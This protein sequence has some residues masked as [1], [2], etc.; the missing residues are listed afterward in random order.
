MTERVLVL[1]P[2]G[3][4]AAN[5]S[6]VLREAGLKP[7]VCKDVRELCAEFS[8]GAGALL[9]AEEALPANDAACLR[10]SLAKQPAWSDIP[11][12]LISH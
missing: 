7:R 2:T 8:E 6:H 12:L 5:V 10:D 9:I 3:S 4:D 11:V 1:T